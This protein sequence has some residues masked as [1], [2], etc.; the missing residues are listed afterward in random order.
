[1]RTVAAIDA[2]LA[3]L[4]VEDSKAILRAK[5]CLEQIE[6]AQRTIRDAETMIGERHQERRTLT[7][8]IAANEAKRVDLMVERREALA[9]QAAGV[10]V[11]AKAA[12]K[13][14]LKVEKA[15]K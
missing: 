15:I 6:T 14:E 10:G 12:P 8:G 7:N 13:P 9:V 2:E 11:G 5:T 4:D 1:M 3:G